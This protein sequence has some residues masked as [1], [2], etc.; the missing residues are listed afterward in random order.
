MSVAEKA[1][2]RKIPEIESYAQG[3]S[4]D[5]C[6]SFSNYYI[7]FFCPGMNQKLID[8]IEQNK[9]GE[10]DY[11][12]QQKIFFS[13]MPEILGLFWDIFGALIPKMTSVYSYQL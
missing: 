6:A 11:T 1:L 13:V 2:L 4:H 10:I 12:S 5:L 8:H 9:K 7:L 3:N